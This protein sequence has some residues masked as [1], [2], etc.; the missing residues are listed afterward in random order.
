MKKKKAGREQSKKN[1][2]NTLDKLFSIYIRKRD[3]D[4]RGNVA[5]YCCYKSIPWQEAQCM[6]YN[7][8]AKMNT[9]WDERNCYAGCVG[10]NVFL[11]GAYPAFTQHLLVRF[12]ERWLHQ[13]I[14]DGD[15]IKKWTP[16][17][18]KTLIKKYEN[19]LNKR[20]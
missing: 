6:H 1:L 18:L 11:H 2:R 4:V 5:C 9:R 13:L 12:G 3:S 10:C 16:E 14:D 20:T 7:S 15:K 8:R 17:E 19:P